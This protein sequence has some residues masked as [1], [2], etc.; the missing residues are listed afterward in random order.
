MTV[1]VRGHPCPSLVGGGDTAAHP[2]LGCS[3]NLT[4]LCPSP[5]RP[6]DKGAVWG[7]PGTS[8]L[9]SPSTH[10]C[11][12]PPKTRPDQSPPPFSQGPQDGVTPTVEGR[13]GDQ[14]TQGHRGPP[15]KPSRAATELCVGTL[16][17]GDSRRQVWDGGVPRRGPRLT[18]SGPA[19]SPAPIQQPKAG[20]GG[21][22]GA[23]DHMCQ[24]ALPGE[25]SRRDWA[26]GCV[27]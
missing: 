26:V 2:R 7:A 17:Q 22:A 13:R 18:D 12:S 25:T 3:P 23:G 16:G 10:N 1:R 21:R 4:L 5:Q 9:P 24:A 14:A 15:Q 8:L 20:C 19:V 27:W 6:E 11:K